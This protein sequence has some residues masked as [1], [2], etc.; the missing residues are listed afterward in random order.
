MISNKKRLDVLKK[1][2]EGLTG[3]GLNFLKKEVEYVIER[4]LTVKE[5]LVP[6]HG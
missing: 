3:G 2:V 6:Y 5:P 1:R 4:R